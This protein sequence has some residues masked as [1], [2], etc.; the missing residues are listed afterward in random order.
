MSLRRASATALKGSE[1][2]AA[3]ATAEKYIPILEY[4]KGG[5]NESENPP[6]HEALLAF[7]LA[8][9]AAATKSPPREAKVVF[10]CEHGAA[11]SV[12]AAAHF[13]RIAR[14]R[15]LPFH[16]VAKGSD[17]QAEA[18]KAA[19]KGLEEERLE[20]LPMKPEA[21]TAADLAGAL[22]VV[23]FDCDVTKVA[24]KGVPVESWSVPAVGDG[25]AAAR[26]AIIEKV[27]K[28]VDELTAPR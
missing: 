20:P 12:V 11:K 26:D 15:G 17:P 6:M 22:R 9:A 18:S 10:V 13:N 2:T 25:Y 16:A 19:V 3:L 24:P 8:F 5:L 4:V 7:V 27:R 21:V 14:E 28:L 1:A 23:T